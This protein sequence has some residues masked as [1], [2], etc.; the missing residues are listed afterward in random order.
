MRTARG[1]IAVAMVNSAKIYMNDLLLFSGKFV[2]F[3]FLKNGVKTSLFLFFIFTSIITQ[4][5]CLCDLSKTF[6]QRLKGAQ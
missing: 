5:A 4:L 6:N 1:E 2:L 3:K